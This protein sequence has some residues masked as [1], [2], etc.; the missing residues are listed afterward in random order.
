[1][2]VLLLLIMM[3]LNVLSTT[4]RRINHSPSSQAPE[5]ERHRPQ[6]RTEGKQ[7]FEEGEPWREGFILQG[8]WLE[9]GFK[10]VAALACKG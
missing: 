2:L 8:H 1:M 6:E 10:G 3:I 5:E 7:H 4:Q 9:E